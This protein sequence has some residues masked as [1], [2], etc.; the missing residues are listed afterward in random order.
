MSMGFDCRPRGG[1]LLVITLLFMALAGSPV[2]A[3]PFAGCGTLV[4]DS[5]GFACSDFMPDG[6]TDIYQL[7]NLGGF[8]VGDHIYVEGTIQTLCATFCWDPLACI[9]VTTIE[10]CVMTEAF[11]E[12]G[13]LVDDGFGCVVLMTADGET[14]GVDDIGAFV[15]GDS[16]FV[17]GTLDVACATFCSI[18][19]GCISGN[20]IEACPTAE[21]RRG[22][23]NNDATVDIGD[24]ISILESLFVV[25]SEPLPCADSGDTNDD[26]GFDISDA[27][28]L[29]S[30]LFT[31][32]GPLP[33][34]GST[35]GADP[36]DDDLD[37]LSSVCI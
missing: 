4:A 30:M 29:L 24:A 1:G 32:T 26:G 2:F 10:D 34:P 20:T 23:A 31:G 19:G 5:S 28:A 21:F 16:V 15:L 36:T 6:T 12:C 11:A 35:C 37:C 22:D 3:Q 13:V 27:I 14:Y 9:E 33:P 8:V 18:T 17:E 25:G 7:N